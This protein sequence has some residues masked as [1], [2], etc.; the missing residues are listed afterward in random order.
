MKY[1]NVPDEQKNMMRMMMFISP[2][3]II[4]MSYI[5]ASALG[6]YWAVGGAFLVVQTWLGNVFY[7]SKVEEEMKPIIE[8]HEKNQQEAN[9]DKKPAKL[10]SNKKKKK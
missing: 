4:W 6:L 1:A 3:M 8:A 10:V 2:I 7:N 5:S 9:N